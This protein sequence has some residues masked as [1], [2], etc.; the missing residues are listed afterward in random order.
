ML[1]VAS[2]SSSWAD[3]RVCS[4]C[5]E[6][7]AAN[8]TSESWALERTSSTVTSDLNWMGSGTTS[9]ITRVIV[10]HTAARA[11]TACLSFWHG[12]PTMADRTHR[13]RRARRG[14][15]RAR[16]RSTARLNG[17]VRKVS[18]REVVR[19]KEI[20]V[21]AL[22]SKATLLQFSTEVCAPCRATARVLDRARRASTSRVEHVDLDITHRPDLA[23]RFSVLQT[24][25]TLILD[26]D[27]TVRARIGGAPAARPSG[28]NSTASWS[29]R[30]SRMTAPPARRASTRADRASP[31]A[32]PPSCC[33]S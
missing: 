33:S 10:G 14:L 31:P 9:T 3:S 4:P 6:T 24:P 18:G 25:T 1:R 12:D 21:T 22:G 5:V 11:A 8:S 16:P 15:D 28:S 17:R 7:R 13:A 32:S 27:G 26:R 19:A 23:A 29:S 2:N 30:C 20:G